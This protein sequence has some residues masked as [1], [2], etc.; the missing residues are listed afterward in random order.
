M[1][2]SISLITLVLKFQCLSS[3]ELLSTLSQ[4]ASYKAAANNSTI[5]PDWLFERV[6]PVLIYHLVGES[7]ERNGCVQIPESY[8]P[9]AVESY[10]SEEMAR[11][12]FQGAF[13]QLNYSIS[14]SKFKE[15]NIMLD[16]KI[17]EAFYI[18]IVQNSLL[19]FN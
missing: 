10:E 11:N 14:P 19:F 13:L 5:L 2:P 4:D 17:I 8:K 3:K 16:R 7:S 9:S 15:I 6:C 18:L 12:M 1:F